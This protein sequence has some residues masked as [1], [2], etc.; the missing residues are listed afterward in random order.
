MS[1]CRTATP[2]PGAP[3][4]DPA[5][6]AAIH[7]YFDPIAAR[8]DLSGVIRVEHRGQVTEVAFGYADWSRR[9]P[10]TPATRFGAGSVAKSV[11]ATVALQLA[12]EGRLN[13]H[14]PVSTWLPAY[15]FGATMTLDDVLR[16][17]AGLPRNVPDA[18]RNAFGPD[19]L[20]DW[21][22]AHAPQKAADGSA[23]YSNV[24]YE[25]LALIAERIT[26][27][28]ID[29]LAQRRIFGP[30]GMLHSSFESHSVNAHATALHVPAPAASGVAPARSEYLPPG[31]Q[32]F[33]SA[34]DLA[35]WG[36]AVRDGTIIS[37]R[38]PDGA[39]SGSVYARPVAGRDALWM[40][41]TIRGGGAV[42][43][44]IPKE[45]LVVVTAMNLETYPLF[46]TEEVVTALVFGED[47]G[48]APVRLPTVALTSA[49]QSLTGRYT[50]PSIGAVSISADDG[51]MWLTMLTS[52]D[53]YHLTPV[54]DTGLV[55]RVFN[56][57]LRPDRTAGGQ[58]TGAR[59]RLQMVG[60]PTP[61]DTTVARMP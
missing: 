19:G 43:A 26:G 15:R 51:A 20:I 33:A 23:S 59:V 55:W 50:L 36:R 1:A 42:V 52:G 25:L 7:R 40:Q 10:I 32:L 8:G 5:L 58:V 49:H 35:R 34:A 39:W 22:N 9:S 3:G 37:L 54:A 48:P 24:G 6:A 41:G 31:G 53:R 47:P 13:R 38:E 16:H 2:A 46:N 27:T 18:D 14:A 45:D 60:Q 30:L 28:P 17:T 12:A 56:V 61:G 57:L 29:T 11:V 4:A 21:L 44:V